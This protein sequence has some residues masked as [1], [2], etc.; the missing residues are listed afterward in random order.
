MRV[1]KVRDYAELSRRAAAFIAGRICAEPCGAFGFATG[2]TPEGAYAEL[3]RMHRCGAVDFG[4]IH[5]FNL[6][7]YCGIPGDHPQSYRHFMM[8]RLFGHVNLKP[9]NVEIPDGMAADLDGECRRYEGRIRELGGISLQLLGIGR[10]GHIGFNEP[11]DVFSGDT[12]V[13]RLTESTVAANS[14]HFAPGEAIPPTAI[15]MGIR[16]IMGARSIL[17]IASGPE[18]RGVL[19]AM[20]NGPIDPRLPASILQAHRDVSVIYC[21]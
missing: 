16:T 9:G 11:G 17:L 4:G 13:F 14:R 15:S 19:D 5:T 2:S 8:D 7:E 21:D 3:V 10:N 6:D 12:A 20:I 1:T 18:K